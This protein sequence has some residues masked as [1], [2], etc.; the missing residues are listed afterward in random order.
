MHSTPLGRFAQY[1]LGKQKAS[2]KD[3]W[4]S[5]QQPETQSS[6]EVQPFPDSTCWEKATPA[7]VAI[8]ASLNIFL[9]RVGI[10]YNN[11]IVM[12]IP[13]SYILQFK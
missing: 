8:V 1:Y 13:L 2:V 4:M 7:T 3:P 5:V 10:K 6:L 11:Y 9:D 12:I